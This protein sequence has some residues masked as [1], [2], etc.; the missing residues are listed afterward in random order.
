MGSGFSSELELLL[1]NVCVVLS[2]CNR[3]HVKYLLKSRLSGRVLAD[4][5]FASKLLHQSK[6]IT[7]RMFC[8]RN[9]KVELVCKV[10]RQVS[11]AK[12]FLKALFEVVAL[13][14]QVG[15]LKYIYYWEWTIPVENL[16]SC[17]C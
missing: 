13:R 9:L 15:P 10:L 12:C 6:Y 11:F 14:L 3:K 17:L 1:G 8:L 7:N 4:A 5:K 16:F 2:L